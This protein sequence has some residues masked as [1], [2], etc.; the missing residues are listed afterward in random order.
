MSK[1]PGPHRRRNERKG[2]LAPAPQRAAFESPGF[3]EAA[4]VTLE[5]GKR[6]LGAKAGLVALYAAGDSRF[7]VGWRD[8]GDLDVDLTIDPPAPLY[9]L[10]RRAVAAGRPVF[11]NK[12]PTR[13]AQRAAAGHGPA[14]RSALVT[15]ILSGGAVAGI[16]VLLGKPGGFSRADYRFATA[17]AEMAAVAMRTSVAV[18]GLQEDQSLLAR[19]LHRGATRL[20]QA[21][22][23]LGTV[24]DNLPD[25]VARFDPDLRSIY[26]GPVVQRL[27]GNP[28]RDFVGKTNREVGLPSNVAAKW[29]AAL[30]R[31][32]ASGQPEQIELAFPLEDGTR[33]FDCRLVPERGVGGDVVSVLAVARDVTDRWLA[34]EAEARAR[35]MA[36]FLSDATV[37]LTRSLDRETVLKT[38]LEQL[39]RI[40][41]CDRASVMVVEETSLVSVRAVFDGERV[42]QLRPEARP[43]LDP[44]QHPIVRDILEKGAAVVVPDVRTRL[45]WTL[46][47]DGD[48]EVCWMGVPLFARGDVAGLFSLSKREPAYFNEE[49][50]RLAETMS[51]QASVAV[52]NAILYEQMRASTIRMQSL[53]RRLVDA[54]EQERRQIA[55]ELHDEAGQSLLLLR[56]GLRLLERQ[57]GGGESVSGQVGELVRRT[58][59]VI[60]GLYRLAADLRPVSLDQVGLEA[61]LRQ[62]AESAASE[63]GL[64]IRFKSR[65]F[66]GDRLPAAVETG[67]YRIAQEAITNVVRHSQASRVD[68]L[69]MHL[70]DRVQ[71]VIE[72]DG[73]GFRLDSTWR[74]D[75]IGL[76]SMRERAE[77]LGGTLTIETSPGMG[78]TVVAEVSSADPN[79]DRG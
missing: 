16:I 73:I 71:L 3:I 5:N 22:E 42:S 52:E 39:R 61:A 1:S 57:I 44:A 2:N 23:T 63:L 20:R 38:L 50:L 27:T 58:D 35:S 49:H 79:L 9:R 56:Y 54:Q 47:T 76:I 17:V 62:Y 40:V 70:G 14:T 68:V 7:E 65:G 24:L 11:S 32:F 31:V 74:T 67:L 53:S 48:S 21:E 8:P 46:P 64:T 36:E 69:V 13:S 15:P 28:V 29:D 75:R 19:E 43:E 60:D 77:A 30:R 4:R 55:R 78:T 6:I 33:Y 25:I 26:V 45:D 59:A 72:D 51:A 12:L 10:S 41:P 18:N 34:Y 37:A 66:T